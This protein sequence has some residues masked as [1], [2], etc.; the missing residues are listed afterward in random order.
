[1]PAP[2]VGAPR[3]LLQRPRPWAWP[4]DQRPGC[5][6]LPAWPSPSRSAGPPWVWSCLLRPFLTPRV[7]PLPCLADPT[8]P[9]RSLSEAPLLLLALPPCPRAIGFFLR[10]LSALTA[11]PSPPH[12]LLSKGSVCPPSPTVSQGSFLPSSHLPPRC[13][14]LASSSRASLGLSEMPAQAGPP[15]CRPPCPAPLTLQPLLGQRTGQQGPFVRS[16]Q[17]Q[18]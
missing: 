1:M 12:R 13:P 7:L 2:Q 4:G 9:C 17:V 5:E 3:P 10:G 6:P 8:F 18:L 14:A 15:P 16:F 11:L